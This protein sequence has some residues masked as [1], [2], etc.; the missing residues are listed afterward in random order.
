MFEVVGWR[1]TTERQHCAAIKSNQSSI[2]ALFITPREVRYNLLLA[3]QQARSHFV[4]IKHSVPT[5]GL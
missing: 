4:K 1:I 3:W 2:V 5:T